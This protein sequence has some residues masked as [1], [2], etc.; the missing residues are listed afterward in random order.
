MH[1][2]RKPAIDD[3]PG[4]EGVGRGDGGPAVE[5]EGRDEGAGDDVVEGP[6]PA[7]RDV[8]WD[9]AAEE[10]D[11][12]DYDYEVEGGGLGEVEDV[13]AEGTDLG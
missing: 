6:A 12:V 11:A 9:Q 4:D 13:S 3:G 8:A 7:V 10:A 2:G 1:A 5:Q